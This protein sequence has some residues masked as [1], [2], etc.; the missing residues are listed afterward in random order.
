[1]GNRTQEDVRDVNGTLRHT[2]S[3]VFS[4]LNRLSQERGALNQVSA[5]SYDNQGNLTSVNGPLSGTGDTTRFAYDAL[6]RLIRVT[7]PDTGQVRTT[8]NAL[9][10]ATQIIDPR[11]LATAYAQ[12]ALDL[13]GSFG[14]LIS[15][16][17]ARG[18]SRVPRRTRLH[19][20]ARGAH[21]R[22]AFVCKNHHICTEFAYDL[23]W[24]PWTPSS[25]TA[26]RQ[27]AAGSVATKRSR[28][29]SP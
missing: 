14:P 20:L 18:N 1:M 5:L 7:A 19:T 2:R 16:R 8:L 26:L 15:G 3:R 28:L 21:G 17:M 13:P 27:A 29:A 22:F 4:T 11:N 6:H 9:D 23:A 10:Q 25:T 24:L 12:N